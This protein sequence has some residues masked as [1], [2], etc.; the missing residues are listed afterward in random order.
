MRPPPAGQLREG[1]KRLAPVTTL[2]EAI[3]ITPVAKGGYGTNSGTPDP[4][5][6]MPIRGHAHFYISC[7][8]ATCLIVHSFVYESGICW[9]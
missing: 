5:R 9:A 1:V 4:E 6:R 3:G 7:F 2:N 8:S